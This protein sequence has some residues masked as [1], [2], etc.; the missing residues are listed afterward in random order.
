MD[1]ES[2]LEQIRDRIIDPHW[3]GALDSGTVH[4]AVLIEPYLGYI[5]DGRKTIESR[6]SKNR[7]PPYGSVSVGDT[8]LLKRS[9]GPVVGAFRVADVISY[10]IG[11]GDLQEIKDGYGAA[12]CVDRNFWR[13]KS[14]ARFATLMKIKMP[15]SFE[16]VTVEKKDRRGWVV[17][18]RG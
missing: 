4:L 9:G 8:V 10:D 12:L 1:S 18:S 3:K 11:P 15:V 7:S 17:L 6:F 13:Q 5:L 16:P 14:G 2:L